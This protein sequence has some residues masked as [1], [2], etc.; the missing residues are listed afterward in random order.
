ML[1]YMKNIGGKISEYAIA[2]PVNLPKYARG[3]YPVGNRPQPLKSPHLPASGEPCQPILASAFR[4][5]HR[6]PAS[7]HK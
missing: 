4:L 6:S 2:P 1:T 3:C 7:L 5:N